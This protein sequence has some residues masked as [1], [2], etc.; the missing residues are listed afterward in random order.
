MATVVCNVTSELYGG[1]L[2]HFIANN[3]VNCN[4]PSMGL[5]LTGQIDNGPGYV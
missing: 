4:E 5:D 3:V 2:Y 1:A